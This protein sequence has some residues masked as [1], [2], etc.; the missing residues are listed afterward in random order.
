MGREFLIPILLFWVF[1]AFRQ[2]LIWT[3]WLQVKE[4]RFDRFE[5]LLT[6]RDGVK[7][8]EL[9]T[10][11]LKFAA[12]FAALF[13][14]SYFLAILLLIYLNVRFAIDIAARTF[15]KPKFT[16][17]AIEI[18]L[19]CVAGVALS[20]GASF[21]TGIIA[22]NLIVGEMLILLCPTLGILWTMPLVER[23]RKMAIRQARLALAEV[24]PVVVAVTGSYGKSTTKEFFAHILKTS[25]T[26]SKT[27][28]SQ[29]TDFGVARAAA[30]LKD[31]EIFVAEVGAYKRGEIRKVA[32]YLKPKVAVV[33]GIEPQHLSLFGSLENIKKAKYELVESLIDGGFAIFNFGCKH[34]REMA[35]W[36]NRHGKKVYSYKVTKDGDSGKYDL[37]ARIKK[38]TPAGVLFEVKM[39]STRH[40]FY[41]PVHGVHFIENLAGAILAARKLGVSWDKIKL[42]C[43]TISSLDRTMTVVKT[44][45]GATVID[46]SYNS[47]PNG[48]RAAIAY[49]SLLKNKKKVI[50]TSGIPELGN[51]TKTV[52]IG[53]GEDMG[54]IADKVI[55]TNRDYEKSLKQG[56]GAGKGMLLVCASIDELF[57]R[58]KYYLGQN[59]VILFEGRMPSRITQLLSE[60]KKESA[61]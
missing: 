38:A 56:L 21:Y 25:F 32:E 53:L 50:V 35:K 57:H 42:A 29:N 18:I 48:F 16:L 58:V 59:N 44:A 10:T 2:I 17:R 19:T 55:L 22:T 1:Q 15:R 27:G 30:A 24:H 7:N 26:V 52:H 46:D 28:G 40:E 36:A 33:T 14:G 11:A 4:Y 43:T 47:T 5:V 31:E 41:A 3:Y 37:T 8:L 61:K 54:K 49:L 20:V 12:L 34:C 9:G 6:S 51:I 13:F 23:S 45:N 60:I 39:G